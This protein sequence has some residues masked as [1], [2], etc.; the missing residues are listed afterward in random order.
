MHTESW[1]SGTEERHLEEPVK[2]RGSLWFSWYRCTKLNFLVSIT[3]SW[4]HK[5]A[6][7]GRWAKGLWDSLCY[8]CSPPANLNYFKIKT[9]FKNET[10]TTF[11]TQSPLNCFRYLPPLLCSPAN[12]PEA[13]QGLCPWVTP[14]AIHPLWA[15]HSAVLHS[16]SGK[17]GL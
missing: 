16:N 13:S 9:I 3:V 17:M 10:C 12:A 1:V 11:L 8:L 7:K 2:P 14:H 6:H 15:W 4:S 5:C